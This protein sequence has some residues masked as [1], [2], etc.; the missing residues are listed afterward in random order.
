[1][2]KDT[3][4]ESWRRKG[5]PLVRTPRSPRSL[6]RRA[7]SS[8]SSAPLSPR[9]SA[10]PQKPQLREG[11][12]PAAAALRPSTLPLQPPKGFTTIPV[13]PLHSPLP[14][15]PQSTPFKGRLS[16]PLQIPTQTARS[17]NGKDRVQNIM[18]Q[19]HAA[20]KLKIRK[21]Q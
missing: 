8:G 4:E 7:W 15:S 9:T 17:K 1:M 5:R 21:A 12:S 10:L 13:L 3:R 14:D 19:E 16:S 2:W 6:A 20:L 18:A 11:R